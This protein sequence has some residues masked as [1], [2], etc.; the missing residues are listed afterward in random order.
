[1]KEEELVRK[2][3]NIVLPDIKLQS[4]QRR[5]R[6]ALL[7]ASYLQRQQRITTLELVKSKLKAGKDIMIR[8]LISRASKVT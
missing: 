3:E 6:M 2:L 8:G 7:A 4:H 1:M 5:L